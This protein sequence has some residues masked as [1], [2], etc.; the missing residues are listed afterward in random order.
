[1]RLTVGTFNIRNLNDRYDERRPLLA[2]AFAAFAPDVAALQEVSFDDQR[3][4]TCRRRQSRTPPRFHR[5]QPAPPRLG[6]L[7]RAHRRRHGAGASFEPGRV[8]HRVLLLLE[9]QSP[10][11]REHPSPPSLR[12]FASPAG[13]RTRLPPTPPSSLATSTPHRACLP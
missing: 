12:R 3:R 1:V 2:A 6:T 4:T 8:A 10:W 5:A 11:G 9:G 13:W 7:S